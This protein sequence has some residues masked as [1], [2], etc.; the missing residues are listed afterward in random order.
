MHSSYTA[1]AQRRAAIAG[2]GAGALKY[3]ILTALL[4]SA[5]C[6]DAVTGRLALRL[7]LLITARFNWRSGCFT[8]GQREMARLWGVTERTAKREIAEMRR[9]GWISVAVPAARGRVAQHRIEMARL[10][11]DTMPHWDAVGPDFAARMTGAPEPETGSNVVPLRGAPPLPPE[12]GSGWSAACARLKAQ[13]SAAYD[14]WFAQLH[15]VGLE[16]GVLR[17]AATS[18]FHADYIRT[19]FLARLRAALAAENREVRE[20]SVEHSV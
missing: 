5:T 1:P 15:P 7:S 6:G 19:H 16:N 14:A 2:P 9:R 12:D 13:D 17:L 4:V 3:D 8:V 11:Q 18:R 20:I 10:L